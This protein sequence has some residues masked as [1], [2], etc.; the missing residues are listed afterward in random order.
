MFCLAEV[1]AA[2]MRV[3]QQEL[4]SNDS[5]RLADMLRQH[6]RAAS[7]SDTDV[8]VGAACHVGS[9]VI[10]DCDTDDTECWL[11]TEYGSSRLKNIWFKQA[12]KSDYDSNLKRSPRTFFNNT[13]VCTCFLYCPATDF[14]HT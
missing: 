12:Q 1:V 11:K 4:G 3:I 2:A 7:A 13:F 8:L 5:C 14:F 10:D 6:V 9:A